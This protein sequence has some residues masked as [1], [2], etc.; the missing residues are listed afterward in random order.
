VSKKNKKNVL[1]LHSGGIDSTA[2]IKY[3]IDRGFEIKTLFIDF[4]QL[5]AKKE[6]LAV[7]RI[8][9]YYNISYSI[10]KIK[11][12]KKFNKGLIHGRNA[13]FLFCAVM[14]RNYDHGIICIGI[15]GGTNYYDCSE[16]FFKE[17]SLLIDQ[18]TNGKV[19]L[20]APFL[21]WDKAEIW[22]FCKMNK[23]PIKLTYSCEMGLSRPCGK[24]QT[25]KDLKKLYARKN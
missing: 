1:V 23:I 18:S 2:C 4:G 7:K 15:H 12:Y 25:C 5:A 11:G 10:L 24:C 22:E 6:I 20:D 14:K 19:L 16:S 9:K 21:K 8:S 17:I 3:Y 13:F